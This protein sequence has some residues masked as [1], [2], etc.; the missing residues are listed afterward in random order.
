MLFA[1]MKDGGLLFCIEYRWLNKKTI[2]NKYPLPLPE[3]LFDC[4]GGSTIFSSI[5][6]CSRYWQVPLRKEDIPKTA[7]KTHWGLYEFLVV[8]FEVSNAPVQLMNLMNDVLADYLDDFVVMFFDDIL[9][10]SKTLEDHAI[11]LRNVLQKLR[12][13]QIYVKVSK[14]EIAYKSIEF[15]GQQ[16][17]PVGMSPTKA[18]I[19]AVCEWDTPRDVKDVRSFLGFAN[20]YRWYIH[21]F[22]KVA[23]PLTKS[24]KKGV[25]WQ[26][27]PCQK[28]AFHQ[29]KQKLCDEPILRFPDPKLPYT[30]VTD[31]LGATV[32]AC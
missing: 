16:V 8:A 5:D 27:G 26:W 29:L 20:Y 13:H 11:H 24:T 31:A 17:T 6:L 4:L 18:K 19:R 9:I 32:G 7:F 10:Y 2:K 28:E 23:H 14:W 12:D 3:E 22:A 30:V 15:L 25:D 1:P 21:Q